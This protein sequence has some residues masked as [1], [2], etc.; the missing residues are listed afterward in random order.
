MET[1]DKKIID[2]LYELIFRMTH[3]LPK[4]RYHGEQ[5]YDAWMEWMQQASIEDEEQKSKKN[6]FVFF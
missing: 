1:Y 4:H 5:A 6:D 3:P 2:D